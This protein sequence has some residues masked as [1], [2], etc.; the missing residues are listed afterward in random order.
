MCY[1]CNKLS[2]SQTELNRIDSESD[3]ATCLRGN[4]RTLPVNW[5]VLE[6]LSQ[7]FWCQRNPHETHLQVIR[8]DSLVNSDF[9]KDR[10]N[11]GNPVLKLNGLA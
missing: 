3:V 8:D 11:F 6:A 5:F 1:I 4:I 9:V 7:R 2:T 10:Y